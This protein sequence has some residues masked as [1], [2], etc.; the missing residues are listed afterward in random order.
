MKH[1]R[2]TLKARIALLEAQQE[3]EKQEFNIQL[4]ATFAS[5]KLSN[6]IKS[7]FRE[8]TE[9]TLEMK[10]NVAEAILPLIMN[11][12]SARLVGKSDKNGFFRVIATVA[13][14]AL[15]N[16][17]A[18]HSHT[19]MEYLSQWLDNFSAFINRSMK[20]AR[21]AEPDEEDTASEEESEAKG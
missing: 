11:Y 16:F 8:L 17:T 9:N 13:Q 2:E 18:K 4:K 21:T 15:T 1:T 6:L 5:L 10:S 14:M 12:I 19:I 3:L 20:K 7:T